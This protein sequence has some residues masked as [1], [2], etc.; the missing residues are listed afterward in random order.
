MILSVL[1]LRNARKPLP[2]RTY[3][4]NFSPAVDIF[5]TACGEPVEI[6]KNTI[7]SAISIDYQKKKIFILDDKGDKNLQEFC[8]QHEVKY[9]CRPTHENRKAGNLNYG[10]AQ[11]SAEFILVLDSD[12]TTNT[13]IIND[14]LAYFQD[15][16]VGY[17]T[18][19]QQF[20]LPKND[21]WG[22][23]DAL[24][25]KAMQASRAHDN[26][27]IST[28]TGVIYRRKALESIGGFQTWSIVEDLYTSLCLHAKQWK[29]CYLSEPY[30]L[31]TA[32]FDIITQYKQR[33]QWAVDSLRITFWD[34]S[35]FK[36]G[37]SLKQRLQYFILSFHYIITGLF[38]PFM[39]I[40]PIWALMTGYSVLIPNIWFIYV[41]IRVQYFF[42]L[43]L[44]LRIASSG[45]STFKAFQMQ[46]GLFPVFFLAILTALG[47][48]SKYTAYTVTSKGVNKYSFFK[49]CERVI[50]Q[51]MIIAMGIAAIIYNYY[52]FA[53]DFWFTLINIFWVLW[54]I[55][56]LSRITLLALWPGLFI[57]EDKFKIKE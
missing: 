15:T 54:G 43:E 19:C 22:N 44:Y 56:T 50:P 35:L 4:G 46:A 41:I 14:I 33:Y 52:F 16:D 2:V 11:T 39:L 10:L 25:Y 13:K 9:F 18:T 6:L 12:Q 21:P 8:Y 38:L 29:S 20:I 7:L 49:R 51:L 28:G 47:S 45:H 34:N 26:A 48:R 32:P 40:L 42:F 57:N 31:G 37:L 55:M 24:F 3:T 36:K 5:I 17:V 27:A 30:T 53:F 1:S 23:S